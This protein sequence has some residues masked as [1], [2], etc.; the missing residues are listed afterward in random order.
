MV[1]LSCFY[2]YWKTFWEEL[3]HLYK[4]VHFVI[5]LIFLVFKNDNNLKIFQSFFKLLMLIIVR[6]YMMYHAA[7]VQKISIAHLYET[8]TKHNAPIKADYALI[9]TA[10]TY[11]FIMSE[12]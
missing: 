7:S 12:Q 10:S 8:P 3:Q 4:G 1:Y 6:V 5:T 2:I 11:Q 9:K